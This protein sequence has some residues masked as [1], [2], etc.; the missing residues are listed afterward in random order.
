MATPHAAKPYLREDWQVGGREVKGMRMERPLK[1]EP[2]WALLL[3]VAEPG[4]GK[5]LPAFKAVGGLLTK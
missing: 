4:M 3:Q 2:S 5:E 1:G